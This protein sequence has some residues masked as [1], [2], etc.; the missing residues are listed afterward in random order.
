MRRGLYFAAGGF[1]FLL[2]LVGMALPLLPTVVFWILAAWC[3]GRS[4]PRFE[5]WLLAH[6]TVGPHIR[7]WR[8]WGA[9]SRK[10]KL[11]A[12]AG[13]AGSAALGLLA[14]R[15]P[16]SLIPLAACLVAGLFIWT[17]PDWPTT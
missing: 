8:D 14:L 2:G 7:A 6:R 11:A 17:R 15:P 16:L 3:F 5:A 1:F 13:L 9:I 12:T 4:Q 10:G